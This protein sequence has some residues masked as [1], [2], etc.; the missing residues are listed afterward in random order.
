M[1]NTQ[2]SIEHLPDSDL[3]DVSESESQNS[4]VD[5]QTNGKNTSDRS[6]IKGNFEC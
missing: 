3:D 5:S 2:K 6:Q 4:D 1:A